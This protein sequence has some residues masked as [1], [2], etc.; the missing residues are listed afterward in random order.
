MERF[1][2]V[3]EAEEIDYCAIGGADVRVS[4]YLLCT[5]SVERDHM[6][7]AAHTWKE[8]TQM[9]DDH[10]PGLVEDVRTQNHK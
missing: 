1:I 5:D 8:C 2:M 6:L 9:F 3:K 7:D 4:P 10:H